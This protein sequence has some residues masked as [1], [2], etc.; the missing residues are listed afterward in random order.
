MRKIKREVLAGISLVSLL[1]FIILLIDISSAPNP[2]DNSVNSFMSGINSRF[3]VD[4]SKIISFVFD[5]KSLLVISLIL[6]VLLLFKYKN[7]KKQAVFLI[8]LMIVAGGAT[9]ILKEVIQRARPANMLMS[10][11]SFSF[12]SGHSA[13]AVV[14]FGLLIY[15]IFSKTQSKKM[16]II[17]PIVSVLMI[18]MIGITRLIL[19]LHWFSDVLAGFLLGAFVLGSGFLIK[20]FFHDKR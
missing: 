20:S 14:F 7:A 16:R 18:L 6:S 3:L 15:V 9:Y 4:F 2:L 17:L 13:I 8:L 10:D 11:S 19:N 5:I 1:F 12:P